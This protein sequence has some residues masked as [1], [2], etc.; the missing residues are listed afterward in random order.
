MYCFSNCFF[1]NVEIQVCSNIKWNYYTFA[2][3]SFSLL[4]NLSS[5]RG[6]SCYSNFNFIP[7]GKFSTLNS[8]I[9]QITEFLLCARKA[10]IFFFPVSIL[11]GDFKMVILVYCIILSQEMGLYLILT[12]LPCKSVILNI[13]G[14]NVF[15]WGKLAKKIG[16]F[17]VKSIFLK[18]EIAG[19]NSSLQ[20]TSLKIIFFCNVL[21]FKGT[22]IKRKSLSALP[23]PAIQF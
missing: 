15:C 5:L 10:L 12:L 3:V 17:W 1:I 11:L 18:H 14:E 2:L 6:A 19:H 4:R 16:Y 13:S 9:Q 7:T 20:L 22:K 21:I 8:F 23:S